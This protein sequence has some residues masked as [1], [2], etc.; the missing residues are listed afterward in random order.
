MRI[1]IDG[2]N[3]V[4]RK[5]GI[6]RYFLDICIC[7][8]ARDHELILYLPDGPH[9]DHDLAFASKIRKANYSNPVSR[10]YW[11]H[12]IL[13]HWVAD[14]RP[15]VFWGPA[16]RLPA[17]R[18]VDVPLVLTIHDLVWRRVPDTMTFTRRLGEKMLMPAALRAADIIC[19]N[20]EATRREIELDYPGY[21]D[22]TRI[23]PP[24]LSL[25]EQS[26]P[27]Q[28]VMDRLSIDREYFLFVGT[29]EPRKN[30]PRLIEAFAQMVASAG[31]NTLLVICGGA[32]WK[33]ADAA[34]L[35]S[36]SGV[37]DLV[38]IANY[39]TDAELS[40]LYKCAIALVAP[41]LHEGFGLPIIEANAFGTPTITADCSS[42]PEVGGRAALYVDP[43][44]AEDI[45]NGLITMLNDKALRSKLARNAR[46]NADRYR[47]ELSVKAMEH[48][49][50]EA[51]SGLSVAQV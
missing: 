7:L 28:M 1:A 29:N 9:P 12:R 32:G 41:S 45:S 34:E 47:P 31:R 16:H 6:A 38:R 15:D 14:D 46:S 43:H 49:L 44:S 18:S 33:T 19:V 50:L 2:R 26:K 37:S 4:H 30:L 8:A 24:A 22:R 35:A 3:L 23:V 17:R 20:S 36:N 21:L 48:A 51:V 39:V 25:E 40:A 10:V 27:D 13:P 42:M 5:T 11:Q